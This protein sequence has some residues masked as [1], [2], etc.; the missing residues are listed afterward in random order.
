MAQEEIAWE[1]CH[2]QPGWFCFCLPC[3]R[4]LIEHR[5]PCRKLEL[6]TCRDPE[7]ELETPIVLPALS[8]R[9]SWSFFICSVFLLSLHPQSLYRL[10]YYL[11]S[12]THWVPLAIESYHFSDIVCVVMQI[13]S[14]SFACYI[15]PVSTYR[16]WML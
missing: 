14:V 15:F 9:L 6:E 8:S 10:S 4:K 1:M 5:F 11:V 7:A 16:T 13:L 3:S 2:L 12:E